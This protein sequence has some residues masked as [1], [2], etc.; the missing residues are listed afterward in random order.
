MSADRTLDGGRRT[1]DSKALTDMPRGPRLIYE[2]IRCIAWPATRIYFRKRMILGRENLRFRGPAIIVVNHP[3][4]FMDVLNSAPEIPR[5]L[6]FLGN[7]G[8]FK[9]PISNFLLRRLFTIPVKRR[10]DVA[11]GETRNNDAAFEASFAHLARGGALFIAAE[12]VSWM[13][14][15]MRPLKTG[16]ARIALGAEA[17]NGWELGVKIIP[18]GLSYDAPDKFRSRVVINVGEPVWAKNWAGQ[19]DQDNVAAVENL[20]QH[21]ENQL[22]NLTIDCRD[23]PGE[24]FVT[25]LETMLDNGPRAAILQNRGT[26]PL[27]L[28]SFSTFDRPHNVGKTNL[29]HL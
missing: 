2:L 12:G 6:Y 20:T 23:E 9:N 17:Q 21:L 19:F 16:A 25:R 27:K 3:N 1:L 18:I 29:F 28:L 26:S 14:R 22:S 24:Q 4:T 15:F 13:N 7:W 5:I 8:L 10:E 11:E